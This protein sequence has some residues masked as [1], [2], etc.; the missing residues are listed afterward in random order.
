[1]SLKYLVSSET[2]TTQV[3]EVTCGST[4]TT[5]VNAT[6]LNELYQHSDSKLGEEKVYINKHE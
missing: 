2:T 1:M 4:T 6:Y 5:T 3:K